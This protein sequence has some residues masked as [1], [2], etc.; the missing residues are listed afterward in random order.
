MLVRISLVIAIL[1]GL[2][3]LYFT[4]VQVSERI[5]N[6]TS[7]RD[8]AQNERQ[9]AQELQRKSERERRQARDE[10]EATNK[11]LAERT[12]A[13]EATA[14]RLA[15]QEKRA[16]ALSEDL[17]RIT[18]ER[19]EAQ[20]ELAVWRQLNVTPEQIRGF[21]QQ[22]AEV[23]EERDNFAEE[24]QILMR[25]NNELQVE[26]A[27]FIGPDLDPKM[28]PVAGKVVAVDPKYDFVVLNVGGNQGVVENGKL[29]INRD[30]KL[31]GRVRVTQVQPDSSIANI[32]PGWSQAGVEVMEGDQ[33]IY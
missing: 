20:T 7:E 6:L 16:N 29:L 23:E 1:A 25:K 3:T 18:G 27:R 15:E 12:T 17:T 30:G 32:M 33:V 8:T 14:V 4:H 26:L 21:K 10:L 28:P 22:L 9:T 31:V 5:V 19:N 13:L 11:E 2:A 24:N